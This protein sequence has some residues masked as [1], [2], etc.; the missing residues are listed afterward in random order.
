MIDPLT[1][2]W[3]IAIPVYI[4]VAALIAFLLYWVIRLGV[5]SGLRDHHRWVSQSA[6]PVETRGSE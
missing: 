2:I 5:R 4:L 6:K 1:L 3:L